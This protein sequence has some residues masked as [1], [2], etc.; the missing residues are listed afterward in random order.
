M[1]AK[2]QMLRELCETHDLYEHAFKEI[3]VDRDKFLKYINKFNDYENIRKI[4]RFIH[5]GNFL[6]TIVM[7]K[8]TLKLFPVHAWQAMK[9]H[10]RD[11]KEVVQLRRV[12]KD[13]Q[14]AWRK[15]PKPRRR[16]NE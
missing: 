4:Y 15:R 5:S 14:E 16:G 10:C 3:G 7:V 1:A 12:T 8:N 11:Q 13:A 2:E 6:T 9:I